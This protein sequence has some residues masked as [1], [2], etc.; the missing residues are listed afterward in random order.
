MGTFY[1]IT[2]KYF[3]DFP[4]DKLMTNKEYVNG[5][6]HNRP[7]YYTFKDKANPIYWVIPISS[8]ISKFQGIYNKKVSQK[9]IC[10]TI[11]FGYVL[12]EK[13]AFL[14]QNMCPVTDEYINNQY[15]DAA[16]GNPVSISTKLSKEIEDKAKKV[17]MLYK[18][19]R[20]DLIFP[21]ITIIE[22]QL[23]AKIKNN[24]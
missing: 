3:T 10:D 21:N 18:R 20:T 22:N 11:V 19:G 9:G 5:K 14:I 4:D 12:G 1:F 16:S 15:L 17:L 6:P 24:N 13:K 8:Q 2:D 7:C 23:L